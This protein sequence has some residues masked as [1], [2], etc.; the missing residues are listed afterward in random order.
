MNAHRAIES[1][2]LDKETM[3]N[4]DAIM[5]RYAELIYNGYWYSKERFQL[6]KIIDHKKIK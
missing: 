1:V 2:T 3:H 5:S 4:K 6:Q